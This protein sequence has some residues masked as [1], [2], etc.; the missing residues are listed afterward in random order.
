MCVCVRV[1][2]CVSVYSVCIRERYMERERE[3]EREREWAHERNPLKITLIRK[4]VK[5]LSSF[6]LDHKTDFLSFD[7]F[8]I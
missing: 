3:R 4:L 7:I 8:I 2:V 1:C 6:F 5:L